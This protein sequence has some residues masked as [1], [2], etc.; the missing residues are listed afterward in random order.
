[1]QIQIQPRQQSINKLYTAGLYN[2]SKTPLLKKS[3]K[4]STVNAMKG[5]SA[6]LEEIE[7]TNSKLQNSNVGETG[8]DT[9]KYDTQIRIGSDHVMGQ[10]L[11]AH[12][13]QTNDSQDHS[14]VDFY[15]SQ[16]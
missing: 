15:T 9:G 14:K 1:M 13:I 2:P 4:K 7:G 16:V 3:A 8:V 10:H 5:C 11:T 12:L 6:S